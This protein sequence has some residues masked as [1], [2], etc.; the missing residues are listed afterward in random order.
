MNRPA[1]TLLSIAAF[2]APVAAA[3]SSQ[4]VRAAATAAPA[5]SAADR[6][7]TIVNV[8][9][10]GSKVWVPGT[11][12]V[13]KGERVEIRLV[14][15]TPSGMHGWAVEKY[16]PM[17]VVVQRNQPEKLEFVADTA[18]IFRIWCQLHP[19]HVGGQRLVLE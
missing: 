10:E 4:P 18:G 7:F 1:L 6:T 13:K 5:A 12:V 19:A 14:N 9:Y 17:G 8:E 3:P 16:L 2:A 15:N 11:L